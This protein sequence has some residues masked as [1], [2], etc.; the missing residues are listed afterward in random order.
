ME[1]VYPISEI[2]KSIQWEGRNTWKPSIFVRFRWCNLQCKWCDSK[3]SRHK[4]YINEIEKYTLEQVVNKIQELDCKHIIFTWWEPALFQKQIQK[5][6]EKLFD[7][8]YSYEIETNWSIDIVTY[9]DQVN[10]SYKLTS[11]WNNEYPL[12]AIDESFDYK[13][14]IDTEDDKNE[15][16]FIIDKYK[17]Q[18]IY[19]MPL[20]RDKESQHRLD[21]AQYCIDKW[22]NYCQ[23]MHLLLFWDK[24]W[25]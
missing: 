4:D 17:L 12:L 11:S 9:F 15:M 24:K 18:N 23:R 16:E 20:G 14:V 8:W 2:F 22:Y 19:I 6:Q 21:I 25:V 10:V 13:F 1:L 3:Y 7:K 5:I